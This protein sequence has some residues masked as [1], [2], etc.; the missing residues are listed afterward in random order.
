M[1]WIFRI[2]AGLVL[3]AI[4]LGALATVLLVEPDPLLPDSPPPTRA[5]IETARAAAE[6]LRA[7]TAPGAAP[8][9]LILEPGQ[10]AALARLA[11]R[12]VPGARSEAVLEEGALT[13]RGSVPLRLIGM[14]PWVNVSVRVPDF[15]G[16]PRLGRVA[17]GRIQLEPAA[18][19]AL[20]RAALR[21]RFGERAARRLD[22][23]SRLTTRPV[24]AM[25]RVGPAEAAAAVLGVDD[26]APYEQAVRAAATAEPNTSLASL[27]REPLHLAADRATA[28]DAPGREMAAAL[29]ALGRLCGTHGLRYGF[30]EL[31]PQGVMARPV[32]L[33][34]TPCGGAGLHGR[35]DLARRFLTAAALEAIGRHH[36][37]GRF[38]PVRTGA[39]LTGPDARFFDPS[40]LVAQRSGRA[41]AVRLLDSP[42]DALQGLAGRIEGEDSVIPALAGLPPPMTIQTF[43]DT[44]GGPRDPRFAALVSEIDDRIARLPIHA[45]LP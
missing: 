19:L 39:A 24:A 18:A 43:R 42:A 37:L 40:H 27:L 23:V 45:V 6:R 11:E 20:G 29:V 44:L 31:L 35:A 26:L 10:V 12:A 30:G 14:G 2:V 32:P 8:H 28:A 15:G 7:A 34:E 1:R 38:E 5:E 16:A 21:A 13:L 25:L 4:A 33:A 17:V 3:A 22:S 41:L 36:T 9:T